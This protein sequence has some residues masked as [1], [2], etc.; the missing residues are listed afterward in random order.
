M[1]E[2]A[3]PQAGAVRRHV[4]LAFVAVAT[5]GLLGTLLAGERAAPLAPKV[6]Q[7]QATITVNDLHAAVALLASDSFYG[8]G[9]GHDG[10]EIAARYLAA[11]L[12]SHDLAPLDARGYLQP[13]DVIT[14]SLGAQ[15][16]LR[17]SADD[18]SP[19]GRGYAPGDHFQPVPESA[20]GEVSG[21]IA[22]AGFGISAPEAGFDD[23]AGLNVT[24]RIVIAFDRAPVNDRGVPLLGAAASE[25]ATAEAK[26]AAARSRGAV[27]LLLVPADRDHR[28]RDLRR[29]WPEAPSVRDRQFFLADA[30]LPLPAA[31]ISGEAA[32]ALLGSGTG[33][34]PSL[35]TLQDALTRRAAGRARQQD[36]ATSFLVAGPGAT[37]R[38]EVNRQPVV[39]HNV[40]AMVE[41]ADPDRA[42][43]LVV[44]GAHFD[45]DGLD[46]EQRV[47][48]GADDNAS[49]VAGVLELAEAF[50]R[51]A[52][53]G[54]RPRR[55]VLFALWNGE[56]R[57][58][59]GSRAF[60][61]S[62]P[63]GRRVVA[64]LNLDMIGRDED[65]P[66]GDRRFDGLA[67]TTASRNTNALHVLGYSHSPD[68]MSVVREAN[69]A[70][71]L[72]LRTTL[73]ES[74]QRLLRRSDQWPF[75]QAGVP[76]LFFFTGLHPDYHTPNDDVEKINFAKMERIVQLVYRVAWRVADADESPRFVDPRPSTEQ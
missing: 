10:N 32:R 29:A 57:G 68:L 50:S 55:S 73:D 13:F 61:S 53:A 45:H 14:P 69:A 6:E 21:A 52:D 65:I 47:Y 46:G 72:T 5:V 62:M 42:G 30:A 33:E 49:G 56:E 15:N 58:L 71:G 35:A 11:A 28:L 60:L 66:A 9:M 70:T 37:L 64:S 74:P 36:P 23:Y 24:G 40:L 7:A 34:T 48:N 54:R 44:V 38:V 63:P 3:K 43:E 4:P 27:A 41:G 8:R 22:F 59:L 19:S 20:T 39:A 31:R 26:A 12:Q 16:E 18:G 51:L 17:L 1:R 2:E 67:P 75:L 25:H 76:A